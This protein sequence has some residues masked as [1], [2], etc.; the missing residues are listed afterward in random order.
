MSFK[1]EDFG[2]K[3][4]DSKICPECGSATLSIEKAKREWDCSNCNYGGTLDVGGYA[5]GKDYTIFSAGEIAPD[6]TNLYDK[7]LERGKNTGWPYLDECFTVRP[8]ELTI[9]GGIPS[10]GKSYFAEALAVNLAFL[11]NWPIAMFSPEHRPHE[12]HVARFVQKFTGR[13]FHKSSHNRVTKQ[14][15]KDTIDWMHNRF[16]FL[17]PPEYSMKSILA[18]AE[19]AW[20]HRGARV[21]LIDPWNTIEYQRVGN[22]TVNEHIGR[23]LL[24]FKKYAQDRGIHIFIIAHPKKMERDKKTGEY[25]VPRP[26]DIAE[27]SLFYSMPDNIIAVWRKVDAAEDHIRNQIQV[28]VQKVKWESVG[29]IGMRELNWRSENGTFHDHTQSM[30]MEYPWDFVYGPGRKRK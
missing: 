15:V 24:G 2:I 17:A 28:H 5:M 30:D 11:H 27:S 7:G 26:Y 1:Y 4:P 10:H 16:I 25:P 6:I 8:G 13:G 14:Q 21:L 18:A 12:M 3:D 19:Q 22:A 9:I 29:K 20:A 23:A